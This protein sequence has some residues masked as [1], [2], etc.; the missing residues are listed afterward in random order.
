M[1]LFFS[2]LAIISL[3]SEVY[4]QSKFNTGKYIYNNHCYMC[5]GVQGEKKALNKSEML[6]N[7]SKQDLVDI[8]NS[9]KFGKHKNK[10][11]LLMQGQIKD[12]NES[13]IDS[14]SEYIEKLK[15]EQY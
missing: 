2:S 3:H 5:H 11:K 7:Y 9:Y 14:L 13:Q 6:T 15:Q 12:L 1:K 10:Y 4:C 8:L